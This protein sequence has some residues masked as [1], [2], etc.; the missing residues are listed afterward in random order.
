MA[1]QIEPKELDMQ[2]QLTR[3]RKAQAEIDKMLDERRKL[4][5]ET[6]VFPA[7][8]IFQAMIATA[9]RLGAG[10]ALGKLFFPG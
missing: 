9:A 2:E 8:L 10:A 4:Q 6:K 5:I 1:T 3:I 7:S